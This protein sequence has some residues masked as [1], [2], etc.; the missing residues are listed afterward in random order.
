MMY[1]KFENPIFITRPLIP[2]YDSVNNRLKQVWESKWL[3]NMGAQH[4]KLEN[5]LKKYLE[6]DNLTLFNN[7]TLALLIG[8]KALNIQGEVITTPFTFPATVEALDWNNIKPIFCDINPD[9]CTIDEDLIESLITEKTTAILGVHVYGNI[10]NVKKIDEIANKYDLKV[11][12]DAAHAFGSFYNDLSIGNYGDMSMFS[13]HAT[14]LFHTIEGGALTFRDDT[15][16][17]SLKLL[18]NFGIKN[19]EEVVVSGLNAKMNEIQAAIGLEVLSMINDERIKRKQIKKQY[20]S[21]LVNIPGISIV[22]NTL[23]NTNSFQYFVIKINEK[24]F[25]KS[26]NWVHTEL[27]KFNII[28]RKYFYPLCSSFSWYNYL[29]SANPKNLPNAV[30]VSQQVLALPFYGDISS[31]IVDKI[32]DIIRSFH[33]S[34]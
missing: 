31:E 24:D 2:K 27:K 4:T 20:I 14:K 13:F 22:T 17:S 19:S 18:K 23:E 9:T 7:G 16:R 8:L 11:V 29:E 1:R 21:N 26:R 12:Y 5:S 30:E 15:L 6:V 28:T 33:A 32:C 10:C 25:G 34:D 3:T